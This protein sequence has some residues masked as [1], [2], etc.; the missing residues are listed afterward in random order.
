M[1]SASCRR[2]L[3]EPTLRMKGRWRKRTPTSTSMREPFGPIQRRR[4]RGRDAS[5]TPLR[6]RAASSPR[7]RGAAPRTRASWRYPAG[8]VAKQVTTQSG[9]RL[10]PTASRDKSRQVRAVRCVSCSRARRHRRPLG[11]GPAGRPSRRVGDRR[12]PDSRGGGHAWLGKG[13]TLDA[14]GRR[15]LAPRACAGGPDPRPPPRPRGGRAA[16]Q[17]RHL[18]S[19]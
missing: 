12:S 19:A 18:P 7:A 13:S 17:R 8:A 11:E 16:R 4:G 1:E 5:V 10:P 15:P 6:L 3:N 9:S 2:M 14:P